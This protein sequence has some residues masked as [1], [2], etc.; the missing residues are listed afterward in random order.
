MGDILIKTDTGTEKIIPEIPD[1]IATEII[2]N[3]NMIIRCGYKEIS[4]IPGVDTIPLFN[5]T[6]LSEMMGVTITDPYKVIAIVENADNTKTEA[7]FQACGYY[8]TRVYNG[9]TYNNV[10]TIRADRA[11]SGTIACTY[12]FIYFNDTDNTT[13]GAYIIADQTRTQS[14]GGSSTGETI[15]NTVDV[16]QKGYD[17]KDIKK[18]IC[19]TT[20]IQLSNNSSKQV[21]NE[22]SMNDLLGSGCNNKNT[23]AYYSNGDGAANGAH[24]DGCTFVPSDGSWRIVLTNG[25]SASGAFRVNYILFRW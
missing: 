15:H 24:I 6:E 17:A 10:W 2:V 4:G 25:T 23:L 8:E 20:V 5:L 11:I 14:S 12:G 21:H 16:L 3:K 13:T 19:G 1:G 18:M 7:H 22:S 9:V